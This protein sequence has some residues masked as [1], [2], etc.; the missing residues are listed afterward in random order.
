M[1]DEKSQDGSKPKVSVSGDLLEL[2]HNASSLE[3]RLLVWNRGNKPTDARDLLKGP[4]NI[5]PTTESSVLGRIKS[6]LPTLDEANRK[7]F[8]DIEINGAEQF[9]IEGVTDADQRYVEMDLALGVADLLTPEAVA[10]AELASNGQVMQINRT[11]G[12]LDS[13]S[14]SDSDEEE[15]HRESDIPTVLGLIRSPEEQNQIPDTQEDTKANRDLKR[16]N[17]EQL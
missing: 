17:I 3:K 1:E 16:K 5:G 4:P 6:F 10:A 14:D 15:G 9:N 7:L 2:E 13:S 11:S 12:A 8:C